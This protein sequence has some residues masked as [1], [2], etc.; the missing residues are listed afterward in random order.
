M[1]NEPVGGEIENKLRNESYKRSEWIVD[2]F[3][4]LVDDFLKEDGVWAMVEESLPDG[5]IIDYKAVFEKAEELIGSGG[6]LTS[7]FEEFADRQWEA[8]NGAE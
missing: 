7:D 6:R 3:D 8:S 2:R 1:L 5:I 4:L